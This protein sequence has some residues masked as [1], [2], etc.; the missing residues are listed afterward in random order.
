MNCPGCGDFETKVIDSRLSKDGLS[1]RRRRQC[2]A[3]FTRFT[4]YEAG[5]K[6][7]LNI[8]IKKKTGHGATASSMKLALSFMAEVLDALLHETY[9]LMDK[10]NKLESMRI[11]RMY[12]PSEPSSGDGASTAMDDTKEKPKQTATGAVLKI[13]KR[14]KKGVHISKL[15]DRTGFDD[16]KIQNI[17]HRACKLG[18]IKRTAKGVYTSS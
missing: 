15:K 14:H 6:D 8:L 3:C 11:S 1:I 12:D 18:K 9:K 4:T 5:E 2:T 16:K 17:L 13:I 7:L 10:M